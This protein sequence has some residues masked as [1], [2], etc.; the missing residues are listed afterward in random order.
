MRGAP[1][2]LY[3]DRA[4]AARMQPCRPTHRS[5]QHAA[6]ALQ[7]IKPL[8]LDVHLEHVGAAEQARLLPRA[9]GLQPEPR[10]RVGVKVAV[11]GASFS[12][13]RLQ[14][15]PHDIVGLR[16]IETRCVAL[17]P[18]E[19]FSASSRLAHLRRASSRRDGARQRRSPWPCARACRQRAPDVPS[20][21]PPCDGP[22]Q[23]SS[24][25]EPRVEI[26]AHLRALHPWIRKA[27]FVVRLLELDADERRLRP[28]S[29][30]SDCAPSGFRCSRRWRRARR[31]TRWVATVPESSP[32]VA[33]CGGERRRRRRGSAPTGGSAALEDSAGSS[34]TDSWISGRPA[35]SAS[36][37]RQ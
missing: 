27:T 5:W 6:Q 32:P 18:T 9:D 16:S 33:L 10:V 12:L 31:W 20:Q 13:R 15:A 22:Y 8:D 1:R 24:R 19:G 34:L 36:G 35:C 30:S 11:I 37:P 4:A 3:D 29:F 7:A 23:T 2:R 14:S 28:L 21:S 17:R 25:R 26:Q